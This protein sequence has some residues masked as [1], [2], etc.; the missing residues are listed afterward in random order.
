M[1]TEEKLPKK[2]KNKWVK[3]LKSSK[4]LQSS[5][6]LFNGEGYCCLGVAAIVCDYKNEE[7]EG[8]G[9]LSADRFPRTPS[10]LQSDRISENPLAQ[11]LANFNDDGKSFKW[12]ASYIERY[13]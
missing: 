2:F 4:Y 11:K 10:I 5:G 3:A 7:V 1:I 8:L 9:W 6:A 13:L 12:I